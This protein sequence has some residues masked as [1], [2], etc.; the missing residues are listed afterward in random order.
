MK[1]SLQLMIPLYPRTN[2]TVWNPVKSD[3]AH[4]EVAD[5]H[6]LR[7]FKLNKG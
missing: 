5:F 4:D 6:K 2:S 7:V 1:I 3:R